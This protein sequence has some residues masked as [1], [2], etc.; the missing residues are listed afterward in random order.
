MQIPDDLFKRAKK[1]AA[2][3]E[4]SF[5]EI[6]RR[7]LEHMVLRHP[8]GDHAS[9]SDWQ[10]PEP[11]DLGLTGDPLADPAW[12]EDANLSASAARLFADRLREDAAR[13]DSA[14]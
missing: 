5:A 11:V 6:V 1:I 7:G 13:Y 12:R 8:P 3:K 14:S 4:W 2:A 10:L 9:L